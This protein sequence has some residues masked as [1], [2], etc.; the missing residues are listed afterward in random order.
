M[1]AVGSDVAPDGRRITVFLSRSQSNVL[2]QDIAR[3]GRV[4][5]VF[6]EPFSHRSVQIKSEQARVRAITPEE[7]AGL[8]RYLQAMQR[9]LDLVG[10]S[11]AFAAAMLAHQVDDLSAVEFEP[12]QAFDQTP[13]PRA[14]DRLTTA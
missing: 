7:V 1:R 9:E 4:S 8:P 10:F 14:G 6:S 12:H 5:V 11:P 3:S 2:L 13:G